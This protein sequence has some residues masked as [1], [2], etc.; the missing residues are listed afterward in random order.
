MANRRMAILATGAAAVMAF[1][2]GVYASASGGSATRTSAGAGSAGDGSEA[3]LE[4]SDR[5]EATPIQG[6]DLAR[7]ERI[8][9][10][11]TGGGT[12]TAT[13]LN[14]EEGYYEIEVGPEGGGQVDVHLDRDFHVLDQSGGG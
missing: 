2:G 4:P 13:E 3:G 11:V 1:G 8:A 7:A 5:G 9:L 10:G 14:D 6:P 12:V